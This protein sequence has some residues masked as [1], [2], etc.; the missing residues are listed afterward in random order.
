MVNYADYMQQAGAFLTHFKPSSSPFSQYQRV[1][2]SY[3]SL[4]SVK[5]AISTTGLSS[6]SYIKGIRIAYGM[7]ENS[8]V[9]Y[10]IP[11]IGT[12]DDEVNNLLLFDLN[13]TSGDLA[14]I[15]NNGTFPVYKS[16]G[17]SLSDIMSSSSEKED[18]ID[19]AENYYTNIQIIDANNSARSYNS[20]TDA[21]AA[22]FPFQEI[23]ALYN[24]YGNPNIYFTSVAFDDGDDI[25]HGIIMSHLDPLTN[26]EFDG[27]SA[28]YNNLCPVNC[29]SVSYPT[30]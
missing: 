28:N 8:I 21:K 20:S 27:H 17:G 13:E 9:L 24:T 30:L 14:T 26:D 23:E 6:G 11:A 19:H 5:N 4:M 29:S 16:S 15:I 12:F 22:F 25:K 2:V 18:A 7:Y 3:S 10:F 1:E